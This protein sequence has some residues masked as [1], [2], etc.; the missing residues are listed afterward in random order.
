MFPPALSAL[1][2]ATLATAPQPGE[3][4]AAI[5]QGMDSPSNVNAITA[6]S[7]G[8]SIQ[9]PDGSTGVE[10][11]YSHARDEGLYDN[12]L[13]A[14]TS[15]TS[16]ALRALMA[17]S[18]AQRYGEASLAS[19]FASG[20]PQQLAGDEGDL[21]N[22]GTEKAAEEQLTGPYQSLLNTQQQQQKAANLDAQYGQ[23][24]RAREEV[25][26]TNA[27]AREQAAQTAADAKGIN[28]KQAFYQGVAKLI[29]S[30][31]MT[32]NSMAQ[33]QAI[34]QKLEALYPD[35]PQTPQIPPD[36]PQQ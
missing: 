19:D 1:R 14:L 8:D 2:S 18:E 34:A 26:N 29:G 30:G 5:L 13:G 7:A 31:K 32:P 21:R 33:L 35:Q 36:Q 11:G 9:L 28:P 3:N 25:A 23:S 6:P 27:G 22:I 17:Q 24:A 10:G 15:T 20:L 12:T 4:G 16:P